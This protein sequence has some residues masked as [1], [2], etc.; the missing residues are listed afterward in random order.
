MNFKIDLI[1][2]IIIFLLIVIIGL[3][4]YVTPIAMKEKK[5]CETCTRKILCENNMLSKNMCISYD[6][7]KNI[8]FNLTSLAT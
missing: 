6:I 7:E 4:L 3:F 8:T 2:M 1:R 5:A